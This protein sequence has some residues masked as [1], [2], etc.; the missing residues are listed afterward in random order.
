[1]V[2]LKHD[3]VNKNISSYFP[4]TSTQAGMIATSDVGSLV[5]IDA[6]LAGIVVPSTGG[7]GILNTTHAEYP[8]VGILTGVE[9]DETTAGSTV[10]K[11]HV[12]PFG[13]NEKLVFDYT[14]VDATITRSDAFLLSSNIGNFVH[15]L[16]SGT[17]SGTAVTAR[18]IDA[19]SGAVAVTSSNPFQMVG[20]ST[21]EKTID[22]LYTGVASTVSGRIL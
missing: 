16:G 8:V 15:V 5:V 7:M 18:F 2:R 3:A 10:S 20:Y 22:V 12:Q 6:A 17:S 1:M 11:V 19:S 9:D 21:K 14:T 13:F 4:D